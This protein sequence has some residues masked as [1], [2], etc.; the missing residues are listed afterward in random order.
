MDEAS[1][2]I[3]ILLVEDD[4]SLQKSLA[5]ILEKEGFKVLCTQTGEEAIIIAR[6]E[7]PDLILLDLVLPGIDG[8]KVCYILKKEAQTANIFIMMLTGKKKLEEIVLGLKE[9]ADDY[10]IKPFEPQILIARIHALLRRKIKFEN[11]DRKSFEFG[12]LTIRLDAYEVIV[13]GERID[14]T[15]TE[16]DIL[17]LL[18][19]KPNHVFTRSR[20]LDCVREDNYS[21]TERVVDYQVTGIRKKLGSAKKYIK[22]VRGVGY[23]F[24]SEPSP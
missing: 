6:K 5:F 11:R 18:A 17:S 16:F 21:I 19:G 14:L 15:K 22:T 10:I 9:Y 1:P 2:S 13:E 7:N 12:S 4:V 20:I 3:K 23:K 8:Y 24:E